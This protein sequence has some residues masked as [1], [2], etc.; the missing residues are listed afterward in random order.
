MTF[1]ISDK[2]VCV[3]DSPF[4]NPHPDLNGITVPLVEGKTYVISRLNDE[5]GVYLAGIKMPRHPNTGTELGFWAHRFR[6][7]TDIQ[8]ENAAKREELIPCGKEARRE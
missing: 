2:V 6:K 8:A 1:R 3:D 4:D 7:L 5:G